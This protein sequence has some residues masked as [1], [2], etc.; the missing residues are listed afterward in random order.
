MLAQDSAQNAPR[1]SFSTLLEERDRWLEEKIRQLSVDVLKKG[2][3]TCTACGEVS[4]AYII[5][6]GEEK[7]RLSAADTYAFLQFI[8]CQD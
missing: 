3:F 7:Y 2:T 6:Q 1:N 4:G 5:A 8:T